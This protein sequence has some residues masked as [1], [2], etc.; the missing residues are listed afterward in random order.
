M[1]EVTYPH[2]EKVGGEPARLKQ[3]PRVRVAQ[4]A[5]EY[6]AHGWTAKEFCT[7]YPHLRPAEVYAALTYYFDHKPEIDAEIEAELEEV[8]RIE[9]QGHTSP[10]YLKLKN[11]G[12]L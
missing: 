3:N 1:V 6:T 7:H 4:I 5:M 9:S 11:T 10:A 8:K 2:I 12:R